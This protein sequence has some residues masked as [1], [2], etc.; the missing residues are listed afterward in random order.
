MARSFPKCVDTVIIGNGP[1]ALILSYILH[2]HIPYYVGGHHDAI[3][4]AKLQNAPNLLHLTPDLYAH[5]LSSLRYST[6]A[7][8]V[9]TLLDTLIRPNADTELNP[10]SC[11][12]WRYEPDKAIPHLAIG[13]TV[14]A[15]GQWAED[16]PSASADI[17]TLSYA[18]QLSLPGYSYADHL[19]RT[20]KIDEAEFIRP[21]R[22]EVADYLKTYPDAVGISDCVLT[23][24]KVD[25]V[26]RTVKGFSIGSLGIRCRHLVLAS[27][28]FTVNIPPPPLLSPI[29]QLNLPEA[30][31]LVIG[32][33]FSAADV[34]ISAPPRRRIIHVYQ[35]NPEK[36]PSP[37]RGCHHTAY[38]EY[39]TVYRQMKLAAIASS[40]KS[41]S[42]RPAY[43]RRRSS[44]FQQRDWTLY[45]GLPGAEV[46]GAYRFGDV[47][48][49]ELRLSSGDIVTREVGGLA[50][51]VGR[52]GTLDFL[53]PELQSEVLSAPD[54][55]PVELLSDNLI[56]GRTLRAKAEAT[57]LEVARDVFITGSLTGDSLIRHAVGGCVFAA[58]R[59]L[60]AIPSMYPSD[61]SLSPALSTPRSTS[62]VSNSDAEAAASE[63]SLSPQRPRT[64][65]RTPSE[66]TNGHEDLHLDRRKL[67]RA[68][69]TAH[70]E[71]R[72]WVDSGWWAGGLGP[73][74]Y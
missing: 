56:S 42:G 36:R 10:K 34:I 54:N 63:I 64:G 38:P 8:P 30:P 49:V 61:N 69:E 62:P 39:A 60:G 65:Q 46:V 17:G 6:Q 66:L 13:E 5:F 23:G 2:G 44:A 24:L 14:H 19:A 12:E 57:S 45:E 51:V 33:G 25:N 3:L 67:F 28:I 20:G 68:V 21:S 15:G 55:V 26:Y 22:T 40:K 58:G 18:E 71:N 9:N 59:I 53:S 35:W 50:Y 70:A 43:A 41:K 52:R 73:G 32:S 16:S 31:L 29:S 72:S 47:A 27:G 37:L 4:D 48:K 7:L 74:R 11:I 1:S